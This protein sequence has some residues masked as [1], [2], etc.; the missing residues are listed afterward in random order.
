MLFWWHI[1]FLLVSC[2]PGVFKNELKDN[3]WG[4]VNIPLESNKSKTSPKGCDGDMV[5]SSTFGCSHS[6]TPSTPRWHSRIDT[7]L[8]F[9]SQPGLLLF[10]DTDLSKG[11]LLQGVAQ[12]AQLIWFIE[13]TKMI[14][15]THGLHFH[16]YSSL[17]SESFVFS[18]LYRCVLWDTST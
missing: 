17:F 5:L 12:K 8:E 9:P 11:L 18:R 4:G 14:V 15:N 10:Y 6:L 16:P 13:F 3:G 1:A 2:H 7:A